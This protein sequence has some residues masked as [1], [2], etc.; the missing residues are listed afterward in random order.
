MYMSEFV[1]VFVYCFFRGFRCANMTAKCTW[2]EEKSTEKRS[3]SDGKDFYI[4]FSF[5]SPSLSTRM[6]LL[7][8]IFGSALL[9]RC[10]SAVFLCLSF[11]ICVQVYVEYPLDNGLYGTMASIDSQTNHHRQKWSNIE[12]N[13]RFRFYF[14]F[15]LCCSGVFSLSM[16]V[17]QF[18]VAPMIQKTLQVCWDDFCFPINKYRSK[19]SRTRTRTLTLT[20]VHSDALCC[21]LS[22]LKCWFWSSSI[23]FHSIPVLFRRRCLQ[24][25]LTHFLTLSFAVQTFYTISF[26][27]RWKE[28]ISNVHCTINPNRSSPL[29]S[30]ISNKEMCPSKSR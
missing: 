20:Y 10:P 23:P 25:H 2:S 26:F 29:C 19:H 15:I 3:T 24:T 1:C 14:I 7:R 30:S 8:V 11:V 12:T 28:K 13:L 22:A 21:F 17:E 4:L 18:L 5:S 6:V 27:L 16:C 9:F